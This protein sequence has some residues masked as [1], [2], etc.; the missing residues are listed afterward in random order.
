MKKAID[1]L[2]ASGNNVNED[3]LK[4]I[5]PLGWEHVNLLGEYTFD[6]R[7]TQGSDELRPL[8]I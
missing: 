5:A 3:L 7:N 4:H 6:L 8:N 1:H 2:K